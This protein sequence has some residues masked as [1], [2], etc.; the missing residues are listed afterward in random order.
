MAEI[1]LRYTKKGQKRYLANVRTIGRNTISKTFSRKTD[2]EMWIFEI[3]KSK[4]T[5]GAK[6]LYEYKKRTLS[7]LIERY[8]TLVLPLRKSDKV[9]Y[10]T[11]LNWW[12]NKIGNYVLGDISSSLIARCRDELLQEPNSNANGE[13]R[14]PI[15]V[16]RYL[17]CLSVVFTYAVNEL[18]WI[19]KNPVSK[20]KKFPEGRGRTRFLSEQE[21]KNLLNISAK[22]RFQSDIYLLIKMALSTGARFG[23]L[24]KLQW[25]NVYLDVEQPFIVFNKT[26]NGE[27]RG[28][29]L[30]PEII[31]MLKQHYANQ[32]VLTKY[33]FPSVDGKTPKDFTWYWQKVLKEAGIENFRFH[34][35]RHTCASYLAIDGC[36]LL[37]IAEVLGHK[38]L[39]MVKRYA[40]LTTKS[41]A[42]ALNSMTAKYMNY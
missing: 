8:I 27:D 10:K 39:A 26:K 17:A 38:T 40:H 15:T 4:Q 42:L 36:S 12:K 9:K 35:L 5:D 28:V 18:E 19:N 11:Y 23:E 31:K 7:E 14:S 29:A 25:Q 21:I 34:D 3:E 20:V 37:Q 30:T 16:N 6:C 41:T 24:Q 22:Y 1:R 2:A 13:H 33:V 32:K